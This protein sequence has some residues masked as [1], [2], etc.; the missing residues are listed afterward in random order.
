MQI[1][2]R[3]LTGKEYRYATLEVDPSESI[4]NVKLKIQDKVGIHPD[5]QY[6]DS[7]RDGLKSLEDGR[8]LS[9]YGIQREDF[10]YLRDMAA[11]SLMRIFVTTLHATLTL[12]LLP[13]D[14]VLA[15]KRQIWG[16][17]DTPPDQQRLTYGGRTLEGGDVSDYGIQKESTLRLVKR[18]SGGKRS[19]YDE[20]TYNKTIAIYLSPYDTVASVKQKIEMKYTMMP[21]FLRERG[22]ILYGGRALQDGTLSDYNV[23][24]HSVLHLTQRMGG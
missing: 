20:T 4:D 14:T 21:G 2:V 6:L 12:H 15:V 10:I 5:W 13:S 11:A 18:G 16:W 1:F 9:D 19:E 8:T 17:E 22:R 7:R 23:K 3:I 24:D